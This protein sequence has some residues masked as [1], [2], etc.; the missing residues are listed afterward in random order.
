MSRLCYD[1][2][3][4]YR[5]DPNTCSE[6]AR[7]RELDSIGQI[8]VKLITNNLNRPLDFQT[9]SDHMDI[10]EDKIRSAIWHCNRDSIKIRSDGLIEKFN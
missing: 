9:I 3:G 8:I 2:C 5:N 1:I 7:V 6:C 4:H 10:S